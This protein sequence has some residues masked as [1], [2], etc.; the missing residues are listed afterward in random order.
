MYRDGL[1]V[2]QDYGKAIGQFR[3][4]AD[5]GHARSMH[6]LSEMYA[7]GQGVKKDAAEA[8]RWSDLA[9]KNGYDG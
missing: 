6:A 4:M 9:V 7:Q 1:G 3:K 8:K 2:K 5:K